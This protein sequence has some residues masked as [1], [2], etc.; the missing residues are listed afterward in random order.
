MQRRH[1]NASCFLVLQVVAKD[2]TGMMI[3]MMELEL[4]KFN[5][6]K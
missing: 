6:I 2:M 5:N 4:E 1:F 3:E